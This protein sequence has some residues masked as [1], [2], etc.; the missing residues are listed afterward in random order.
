LGHHIVAG[1]PKKTIEIFGNVKMDGGKSV[2]I[3]EKWLAKRPF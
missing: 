1:K 3:A 2:S